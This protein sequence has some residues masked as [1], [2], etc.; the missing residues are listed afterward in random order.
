MI[1]FLLGIFIGCFLG[2]LMTSL[3]SVG[4]NAD[5]MLE[6]IETEMVKEQV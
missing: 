5:E 3:F 1:L 4:K 2:V 6:M